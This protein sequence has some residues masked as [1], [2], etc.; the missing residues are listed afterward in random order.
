MIRGGDL[1]GDRVN[2]AARL[3]SL[4]HPGGVCLS[5]EAHQYSRNVLPLAYEDLGHQTVRNI[6]EPIRAYAVKP[7]RL[8][9]SETGPPEESER[10][11]VL[12]P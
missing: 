7:A 2:V 1:L 5:G 12:A 4:A 9:G 11:L 10:R 3:Q 8:V 6:E